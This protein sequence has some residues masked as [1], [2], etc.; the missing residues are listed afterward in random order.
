[1]TE[2]LSLFTFRRIDQGG[3]YLLSRCF[4]LPCFNPAAEISTGIP[5]KAYKDLQGPTLGILVLD[6]DQ[7]KRGHGLPRWC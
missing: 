1:M 6:Y 4:Y 3:A 2:Q 7:S 5:L